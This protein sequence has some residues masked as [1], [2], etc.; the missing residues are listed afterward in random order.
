MV[1]SVP[2][3]SAL[4]A[5]KWWIREKSENTH[6]MVHLGLLF[7]LI[8][9][10]M[11][12]DIKGND[13]YQLSCFLPYNKYPLNSFWIQGSGAARTNRMQTR[14]HADF[15]FLQTLSAP[16]TLYGEALQQRNRQSIC[17][18]WGREELVQWE[19]SSKALRNEYDLTGIEGSVGLCNTITCSG[20]G[21]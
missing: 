14:P 7:L 9:G 12:T 10:F 5:P 11:V 2:W 4:S 19:K 15:I 20:E 16:I 8:W 17:G 18:P 21:D 3:N 13:G 1:V 6:F